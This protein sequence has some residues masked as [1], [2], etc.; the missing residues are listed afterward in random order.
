MERPRSRTGESLPCDFCSERA[1]VLYCRADSARL[2]L[3]CDQHV[4][5]A[6]S[7]SRKHIRSQICDNCDAKPVSVRCFT[8]N[9]IL[10]QECDWD[11]H[12]SSPVSASHDRTSVDGFS[13]CPSALELAALWGQDLDDKKQ[14]G[15]PGQHNQNSSTQS[16]AF[17]FQELL[18]PCEDA[19]FFADMTFG[20]ILD[21]PKRQNSSCGRYKHVIH[22]QLLELSKQDVVD[23]HDDGGGCE[24]GGG[25]V[26]GENTVPGTSNRRNACGRKLDRIDMSVIGCGATSS[27]VSPVPSQGGVF[28]SRPT[29]PAQGDLKESVNGDALWESNPIGNA[30]VRTASILILFHENF[31]SK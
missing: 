11:A 18:V 17:G 20:E 19:L 25:G 26:C 22:E 8:D 6:N 29:M 12:G 4:H 7:L 16:V 2:C 5:S 27:A 15:L 31:L 3:F 30:Q 1:A 23:G 14:P 9:L 21:L 28:M 13:G 10:C 24:N